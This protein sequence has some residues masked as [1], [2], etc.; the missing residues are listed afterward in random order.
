MAS[1]PAH[2]HTNAHIQ[3]HKHTHTV[4]PLIILL[5]SSS[6]FI[7]IDEPILSTIV[8]SLNQSLFWFCTVQWILTN[9][10]GLV[11]TITIP[12]RIM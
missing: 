11:P 8:Q 4:S 1:M 6:K 7:T 10:L 3:T 9:V 2:T 12:Y 5:Y